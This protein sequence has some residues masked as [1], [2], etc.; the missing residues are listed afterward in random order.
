VIAS[1][2]GQRAPSTL[3]IG[4]GVSAFANDRL[5]H[6][7]RALFGIGVAA[8]GLQSFVYSEFLAGLQPMPSTAPG[9]MLLGAFMALVLICA[10]A[11]IAL[12][13]RLRV[14]AAA[15][16]ALLLAW[17]LFLHV[18]ALARSP[19]N[20]ATWGSAFH[21]LALCGCAWVLAGA[22]AEDRL[23]YSRENRLIT[24]ATT[25]AC[26]AFGLAL[27]AFGA[28]HLVYRDYIGGL[29][30]GWI[31]GRALLPFVTAAAQIAAGLGLVFRVK[32][33]LAAVLVGAMYG[34]W[35]LVLHVPT[36][37]AVPGDR[38]EWTKLLLA[39]ALSGGAWIVATSADRASAP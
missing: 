14:C 6:P 25:P 1:E 2:S 19:S 13:A 28:L 17:I 18:P 7:G 39:V 23:L 32:A 15:L 31:P 3:A 36:V 20:G 29:I 10:G 33:R 24:R 27:L 37:L 34:S 11:G 4:S 9:R 26:L 21:V 35:V 12:N 30:P 38:T 16:G 5:G 22:A 8:M